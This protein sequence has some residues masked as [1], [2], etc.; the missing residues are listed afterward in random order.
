MAERLNPF[1][2]IGEGVLQIAETLKNAEGKVIGSRLLAL[3]GPGEIVKEAEHLAALGAERITHFHKAGTAVAVE[4]RV[5]PASVMTDSEKKQAEDVTRDALAGS[6]GA[7]QQ[8]EAT[9]VAQKGP[10]Q[11]KAEADAAAPLAAPT[12]APS[13]NAGTGA[14]PISAGS[15]K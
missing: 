8:A 5:Q 2:W 15:T 9:N 1:K 4:S 12:A 10:A 14:G 6:A 7:H 13:R 3:I 11:A